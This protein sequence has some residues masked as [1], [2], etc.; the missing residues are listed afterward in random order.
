MTIKVGDIVKGFTLK[1]QYGE[2]FDLN[3]ILGK[4]P[5]I[6]YFYPKD[7]TPGCVRQACS[8]RDNYRFFLERDI[9]IIGISGDSTASH[10]RFSDKYNLPFKVLSDKRNRVRKMFNV[11]GNLFGIIPGRVTYYV[12]RDGRVKYIFDSLLDAEKHIE[13]AKW[14]ATNSSV[15]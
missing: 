12:D 2:V 6:L 10:K 5:F 14:C 13:K 15:D 4:K 1:D 3:N 8:F 9:E 11:P 7:N